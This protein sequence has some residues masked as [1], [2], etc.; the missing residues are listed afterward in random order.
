MNHLNAYCNTLNHWSS[1][2]E[3]PKGP[4][5]KDVT[6]IPGHSHGGEVPFIPMKADQWRMNPK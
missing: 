2:H 1:Q 6:I 3:P 4:K 5:V